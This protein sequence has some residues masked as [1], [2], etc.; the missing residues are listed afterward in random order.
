MLST[1]V[2]EKKM[3]PSENLMSQYAEPKL[4]P[5]VSENETVKVV[6]DVTTTVQEYSFP[7]ESRMSE[8]MVKPVKLGGDPVLAV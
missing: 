2:S 4:Q 7:E 3:M 1:A 5:E 6:D 8:V